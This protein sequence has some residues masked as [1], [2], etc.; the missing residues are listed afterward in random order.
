M[1]VAIVRSLISSIASLSITAMVDGCGLVRGKIGK[2]SV[3]LNVVSVPIA[4]IVEDV[5][6]HGKFIHM[7][8]CYCFNRSLSGR[9]W[10]QW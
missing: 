9:C 5:G 7:I 4:A 8:C 10:L 2:A 6:Y 1:L 3:D